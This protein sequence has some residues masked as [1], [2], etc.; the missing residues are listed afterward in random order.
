[1]LVSKLFTLSTA[2]PAVI[3]GVAADVLVAGSEIFQGDDYVEAINAL[4]P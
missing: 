4:K 3:T 2:P 1:V